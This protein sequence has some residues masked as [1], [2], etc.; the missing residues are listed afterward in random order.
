MRSRPI[1][2]YSLLALLVLGASGATPETMPLRELTGK[3]V[4]EL[5]LAALS[6]EARRLPGL[7][8]EV[9]GNPTFARYQFVT[10]TWGVPRGEAGGTVTHVAVDTVTADV[11][12]GLVCKEHSS[13]TLRKSQSAIRKRIGLSNEL[14]RTLKRKGPMC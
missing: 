10:V 9:Q 1:Q 13:S 2:Q 5:T 7:E 8:L 6:P 4:R 3:E 12:S 14:Y 11:W